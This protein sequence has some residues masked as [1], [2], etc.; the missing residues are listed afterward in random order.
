MS[1]KMSMT[2]VAEVAYQAGFR[3]EDLKIAVAVAWAES[4]GDPKVNSHYPGEDSRGLWQINEVHFGRYDESRL[5]QPRYNA[6]A[7]RDIWRDSTQAG[8]PP[9]YPW[10]TWRFGNYEQYMDD[11]RRAVKR[12]DLGGRGGSGGHGGRGHRHVHDI[13]PWRLPRKGGPVKVDP[14]RLRALAEQL[15]D[16][17]AVVESVYHR[18]DRALDELGRVQVAG[19]TLE[20][21]VR[22]KLH[23]A[24]NDWEG[25]RRLP[26]LMTK[27]IGYV[28]EVKRR[29]DHADA[30]GAKRT[31]EGLIG[32]LASRGTHTRRHTAELLRSLYRPDKHNGHLHTHLPKPV[33]PPKGP[34][35]GG[36][37]GGGGHGGGGRGLG[38]V[39]LGKSWAGTKSIFNQF[40]TPFMKRLGLDAGS[41]KRPYD[42]VDGPNMSDHYTG[43]T[44]SYAVDYPTYSGEDEARKLAKAMGID[45]W[46]PNSYESH[47]VTVDGVRFRVQILWGSAIEH[48]DHVHVGIRRA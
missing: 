3:G 40:V 1:D 32:V 17:L 45:G 9:W 10:S 31:V 26:Y 14:A 15:T 33:H 6:E 29:V 30:G 21:Q 46:Q 43:S 27:D 42:T 19:D 41:E 2:E 47:Y 16:C 37:H 36:G 13:R 5:Y 38:G 22:R 8:N 48:G 25:L 7:A 39:D 4:G 28:V 20:D 35:H 11:A 12:A 23:R 18:C 44:S 34:G 24:V